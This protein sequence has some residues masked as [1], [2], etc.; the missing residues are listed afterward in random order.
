MGILFSTYLAPAW[1][2]IYGEYPGL[3]NRF[4]VT[5][6]S[7]SIGEEEIKLLLNWMSRVFISLSRVYRHAT[8]QLHFPYLAV[9][10]HQ[11]LREG[12]IVPHRADVRRPPYGHSPHAEIRVPVAGRDTSANTP[13]VRSFP[14]G[15]GNEPPPERGGVDNVPYIFG[16]RPLCPR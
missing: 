15:A 10:F 9:R 11:Q 7:K 16:A 6:S 13:D 5:D 3:F 1:V 12:N 8:L 14:E 2:L 4:I